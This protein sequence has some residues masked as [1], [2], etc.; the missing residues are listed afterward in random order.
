MHVKKKKKTTQIF[1]NKQTTKKNW[2]PRKS[3]GLKKENLETKL[4]KSIEKN[5]T[6]FVRDVLKYM[7][8]P[9]WWEK[10]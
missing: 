1:L 8:L 2:R 9:S 10:K 6:M 7:K 3:K 5:K 4:L